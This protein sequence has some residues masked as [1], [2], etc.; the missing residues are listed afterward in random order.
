MPCHNV[1]RSL[2]LEE[3]NKNLNP[4]VVAYIEKFFY[5][6]L[7]KVRK[8]VLE[9]I[10]RCN[11]AVRIGKCCS[12]SHFLRRKLSQVSTSAGGIQVS[13]TFPMQHVGGLI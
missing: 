5:G 4:R 11:Q 8:R 7:Q 12:V 2:A 3:P 9:W 1:A 13:K 10:D 6:K